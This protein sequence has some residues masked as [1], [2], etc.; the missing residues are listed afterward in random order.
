M[1]GLVIVFNNIAVCIFGCVLSAAFCAMGKSAKSRW[2]M[3]GMTAAML[4]LQGCVSFFF[5]VECL[6]RF[7]PLV[8]HL[9]LALALWGLQKKGQWAFTSVF[10]AY[11]CCQLRRWL[12][13]LI[14]A[15]APGEDALLLATIELFLTLPM[16]VLF[17]RFVAPPVSRLADRPLSVRWQFCLVPALYYFYDYI[18]IVYTD[19][20]YSGVPAVV[21]FMPFVCCA[22]YLTFLLYTCAAEKK[23]HMLEL[24]RNNLNLR[25]TQSLRELSALRESQQQ[26]SIFRHDLRH[27]LQYLSS[28]MENGQ[29]ANAQA[30]IQ[31]I[32]AQIEAQKMIAYCN[33]EAVN[34]VLSAYAQRAERCGVTLEVKAALPE[35]TGVSNSDLCVLL[36]NGLE[37]AL[38]A[39]RSLNAAE[40]ARRIQVECYEK[41]GK[42][43]LQIANPCQEGIS[44]EDGLPLACRP[45]H[46]TGT[47]SIRAIVERYGGLCSFSTRD[48]QFFL[49]VSL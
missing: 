14:V 13:L 24:E 25:M 27:H 5:G 6:R 47:R 43:L 10:L 22:A 38:N 44:F 41:N 1:S 15:L 28:C 19:W 12:A 23:R 48:G 16:L 40:T 11:L 26:A 45:G 32:Y 4:A 20:L 8:T 30:Y 33:N 46:G 2:A 31:D 39:C 18:A 42:L 3:A 36:S 7:Y 49:R 35:I 34:L 17:L 9:P 21:E 37:N 29:I